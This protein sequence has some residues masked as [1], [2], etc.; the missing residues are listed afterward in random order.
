[1]VHIIF[2][3][4]AD[5]DLFCS[6]LES[7]DELVIN[8]ILYVDTRRRGADLWLVHEHPDQAAPFDGLVEI[9]IVE[10]NGSVGQHCQASVLTQWQETFHQ[11]QALR[12]LNL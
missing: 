8:A 9:R 12:F 2:V 4:A 6:R 5:Y 1:V 3:G 11:A 10:A 7:L